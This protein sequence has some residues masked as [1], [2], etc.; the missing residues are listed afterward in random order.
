MFGRGFGE[1]LCVHSGEGEWIVVDSCLKP[2]TGRPAA[3]DYLERM[4]VD[5]KQAVRLVVA[6]HWDDDHI[7]GLSE[8]AEACEAAAIAC[9]AALR[10]EEIFAFVARQG[11]GRGALGSGVD[12]L[13]R[14]LLL[15][16]KRG[17][18]IWAKANL[19][20]HPR[21]PGDSPTVVA[22]SPSED[23]VARSIE[24]LIGAATQAESTVQRR[25]KA[26][27]GPNGASIATVV[28]RGEQALLLGA[29]LERSANEETGW[30][31]VVAH[32]KPS[33][34]ASLV[35]IPHHGS[36]GAHHDGMW[37][38][39]VEEEAVAVVTPWTKG[40]MY[41]PTDR[42]LDR[43]RGLAGRV[44][45]TAMPGLKRV[46]RDAAVEKLIRKLHGDKL[47]ELRGWGHVRARLGGGEA[48]W[49]VDLDGDACQV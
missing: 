16:N 8:T 36:E 30:Q 35:K 9:S 4:G 29:D 40:A 10:R 1:C 20:L 17:S 21:P 43:L 42:D 27:E 25:Y 7:R 12:E 49:Q 47:E 48:G 22:L 44:F 39:L 15:S 5:P 6:T 26:P 32:A 11:H 28:R 46:K 31:A 23:A 38:E 45:L 18:I 33:A 37:H 41:L 3:L 34:A 24:A 14:I 13:R 2:D 19:P